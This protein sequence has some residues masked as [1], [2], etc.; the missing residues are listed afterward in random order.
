[1]SVAIASY[2]GEK[3]IREQL[4]SIYN[5]SYKNLEVVVTDDCSSDKTVEILKEYHEKHGLRYYVNDKNLG[6][7]KNFEKAISL[8]GGK[9]IA[10]ADQDDVWKPQKI[11][12]LVNEIGEYTL[13]YSHAIEVID[14][15]GIVKY[16]FPNTYLIN[17]YGTGKPTRRLIAFNFIASH[18]ILF[19]RDLLELALPIPPGQH[20]HDAWIAVVASKM[21]GIKFVN[22]DLM[23]YREHEESLTYTSHDA[24]PKMTERLKRF[25]LDSQRK[26]M[27]NQKIK[28]EI[29]RLKQMQQY[30]IFDSSDKEFIGNL[31]TYYQGRL[32]SGIHWRSFWFAIKNFDLHRYNSY[33]EKTKFLLDSLV[34]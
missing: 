34:N 7:I 16:K 10:L 17:N 24:L 19:H 25:L 15:K 11:E 13:A 21:N 30:N 14:G 23:Y 9:Y 20:Y 5:Q 1:V 28:E 26:E 33:Q 18:Q 3:F 12:T 29:C 22:K 32:K 31:I 4:D 8:C 2:N 27:K 6:L